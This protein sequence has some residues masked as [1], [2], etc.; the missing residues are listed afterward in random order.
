MLLNL[1]YILIICLNLKKERF[2]YVVFSIYDIDLI[3]V[4]DCVLGYLS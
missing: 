1:I 4:N 2:D 3:N